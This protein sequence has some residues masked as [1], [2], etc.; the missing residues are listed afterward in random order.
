MHW[1]SGIEV[2]LRLIAWT[3]VRRL[4]EGWDGARALFE[5]NEE[6]LAQIW[7]HQHY[8]ANFRSRGSSANNHVIAEAAGQLVGGLAFGWF[9]ES[10]GWARQASQLLQDELTKNTFPSGVNREM[11]FDYHGFVAEL[12]P[13]GRSRGG[14]GAAIRSPRPPGRRC[15]AWST[16]R[17]PWSTRRIGLPA[18]EIATMAGPWFWDQPRTTGGRACW[19]WAGRCS[20][21]R[22]GGQRRRRTRSASWW[23]RWPE[24][25][26]N[27]GGLPGAPATSTTPVSPSCAAPTSDGPEIWCR[28]DGGPHGFLSIA[29]HAHADALSVEVRHAG[30]EIL[31]DPGTYCYGSEPDWRSYFK[32]T[33]G[34]NTVEIANRDQSRSGGPTLWI[35][36]ARTR[37]VNLDTDHSGDLRSW[38][39]EHDGYTSLDPPASHQRTVRL[40]SAHRRIEITDEIR[41]AGAHP[42][43]LA[44]HLGPTVRAELDDHAV[45]LR[46]DSGE[47]SRESATLQLPAGLHWTLVRASTHPIL[48]WYSRGFGQ[49]EP[50]TTVLGEGTCAGSRQ[51]QTVLQ[52]APS[53]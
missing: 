25:K 38:S 46:W 23:R 24:I 34:H 15:V 49:K 45:A 3:W 52:F 21:H 53:T 27:W 19:R 48:G 14:A 31:V 26:L 40:E 33:L 36:G 37:L 47:P 18:R 12:G 10:E 5:D 13:P 4:L 43:R 22:T 7:W 11:A 51:F 9:E 2:G 20:A 50:T 17:P 44:F 8:L 1:T 35:R 41:T 30:V 32:S 42:I 6:A 29:A 28:C 39:A 16:W